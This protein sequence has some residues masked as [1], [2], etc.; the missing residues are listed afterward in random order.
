MEPEV[1]GDEADLDEK[2]RE[3]NVQVLFDKLQAS[4]EL[5]P[6]KSVSKE[7]L[8][9]YAGELLTSTSVSRRVLFCLKM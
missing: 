5:D 2:E 8:H 3:V 4:T 9:Q 7:E 6:S 1:D